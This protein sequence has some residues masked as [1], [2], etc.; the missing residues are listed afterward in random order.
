MLVTGLADSVQH[1]DLMNKWGTPYYEGVSVK[2]MQVKGLLFGEDDALTGGTFNSN[3]EQVLEICKE[4]F[5]L[6]GH[7]KTAKEFAEEFLFAKMMKNARDGIHSI[8]VLSQFLKMVNIINGYATEVSA[9]FELLSK[10]KDLEACNKNMKLYFANCGEKVCAVDNLAT[11]IELMTI[12][13]MIHSNTLSFG[14]FTLTEPVATRISNWETYG[15]E[16]NFLFGTAGTMVGVNYEVHV[17][18]DQMYP[19]G[20]M[21]MGLREVITKYAAMSDQLKS[22]YFKKISKDPKFVDYGWIMTDYC[23]DGIDGKSM[24]LT[25]YI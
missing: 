9:E 24:T 1:S 14:R 3:R 23:N 8:G 22:E 25:S 5:V 6:W 2:F 11:W 13:G 12:T 18:S 19:K 20:T 7:C 17:L 21:V 10:G 4:F 15:E 16:V